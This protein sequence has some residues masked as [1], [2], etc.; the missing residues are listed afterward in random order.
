MSK[1]KIV[2]HASGS[3]VLTIAAPNT[4][5]DRTITIPDVTGTLLDSGSDLP[6][7]NL[8]GTVADARISALTAS[9]LTGA[10][11]AIS[12]ANLTAIP[13]ANITGTLPAIS[14]TNL[15]NVPAAN[16]TG[17][18]PAIS[19]ANLTNVPAANIT[20]TLPALNGSALTGIAGRKN[21]FINGNFSVNQRG[22]GATSGGTYLTADRWKA[23]Q[24]NVTFQT[25]ANDRDLSI[26]N[27]LKVT[28]HTNGYGIIVQ[29][30]EDVRTTSGQ[31]VTLSFWAKTANF[32]S[33]RLELQQNFG[34]GGS[35]T[36]TVV[37]NASYFSVPDTGWNKYTATI[38]IPSISGKTVG[39]SSYFN[40]VLGPNS[41]TSGGITYFSEV[42]LELGSVAT[43][44]EHR[45]F[46]E[47]LAL[48]KR[49]YEKSFA[50][51]TVPANGASATSFLTEHGIATL[52]VLL[53]SNPNARTFAY[54]VEK[55]ATPT[56]TR[57]GNSSGY[58]GYINAGTSPSGSDNTPI[59]HQNIFCQA[60]STNT[61]VVTNQTSGNPLWSV[62]GHWTADAEI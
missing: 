17:T 34:S 55:R 40:M 61:L 41:G 21:I 8:T 38:A 54:E 4:D 29:A 10:L 42:Q 58:W 62:R 57:Y 44:F 43:D 32:S 25:V 28:S 36:V 26:A 53:W 3:G 39:T 35:A 47:E 56:V 19:G 1:I 6:A 31:N 9:K 7:A 2:G 15:T 24:T 11:P 49:Y 48:C 33:F 23:G 5:T 20:G 22:T 16:I 51:G 46:G 14:A 18:L 45:S 52:G 59:F 27:M 37:N 50:Y 13:A 12:A 60:Q 30:A